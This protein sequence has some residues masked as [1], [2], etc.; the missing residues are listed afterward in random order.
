MCVILLQINTIKA[1]PVQLLRGK[2]MLK[3]KVIARFFF[4]FFF[5]K[6]IYFLNV[7]SVSWK[8]CLFVIDFKF[9]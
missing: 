1:F 5:V 4:F 9:I 2:I 7:S 3:Q 8:N 6:S